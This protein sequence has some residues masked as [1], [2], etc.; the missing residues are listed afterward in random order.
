MALPQKHSSV[1]TRY[2]IDTR[3][4]VPSNSKQPYSLPLLELLTFADQEAVTRFLRPADKFMSLASALLKYTFIHRQA[5]IPWSKVAIQRTPV[6]HRRPY[7][8]PPDDWESE[9]KSGGLEFNVTHQAGMVV[10]IGCTTPTAQLPTSSSL[11]AKMDH[12]DLTGHHTPGLASSP[13]QVRLGIDIACADEDKRTPK[14]MTTQAKFDEWVDIFGE[15]FS[16]RERRDMRHAPVHMP[17]AEREEGAWDTESSSSSSEGRGATTEAARLRR[18]RE[19]EAK[20]TQLKLRRFYA[21]WALKE[22]YIKMVGEGLLASWLKELEF[23]DVTAPVSPSARISSRAKSHSRSRSRGT[24]AA[25][26][27]NHGHQHQHHHHSSSVSTPV[28]DR[29]AEE[30]AKWTHPS[31][32]EKGMQTLL[33]GRKLDDVDIEL[34]AYDE[35]FLLATAMQGVVEVFE[36]QQSATS[37]LR[38]SSS[39]ENGSVDVQAAVVQPEPQRKRWIRLDIEKDI[40]P[41]AEGRCRCLD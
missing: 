41:C 38:D 14:D 19:N 3:P 21:Y 26:S 30:A 8:Q 5:K 32:A 4:L 25:H 28:L 31:K 29:D 37:A 1:I 33:R 23:L 39:V 35:D 24:V 40:R 7:W 11:S 13:H 15:M 17:V 16:E 36:E 6:P 12:L 20:V 10:I 18:A 9:S 22:A 2:Y 34:V 27:R